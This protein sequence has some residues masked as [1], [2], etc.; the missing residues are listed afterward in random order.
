[1]KNYAEGE[2][3]LFQPRKMLI[4]RFTS[5]NGTVITPLL[6]FYSQ[7]G[8]VCTKIHR[9]VEYTSNKCFN[10]FVQSAVD[11]KRQGEENPKTNVVAGTTKLLDSNS[12]G[13]QIMYRT[14]H[15]VMKYF[16]DA[17]THA[18]IKST[19]FK[20]LDQVNTSLQE[21]ELAK[22]QIEHK[23]PIIFGFLILKYA[24]L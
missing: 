24:K 8:L 15:T 7:L 17:K 4:S 20:K 5:Q 12:C 13:Y 23:E 21:V 16:T 18:A 3:L 9:F 1:M 22:D 14:R 10:S 11:T 19:L 2:R 6:L